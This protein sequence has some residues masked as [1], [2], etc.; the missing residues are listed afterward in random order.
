MRFCFT[1][2]VLFLHTL[3]LHKVNLSKGL[4]A[5]YPF[6]GDAKD[7]SGNNNHPVY[8]NAPNTYKWPYRYS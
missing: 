3:H 2:T 8:N 4:A 1:L 6:D 7:E 5:Y